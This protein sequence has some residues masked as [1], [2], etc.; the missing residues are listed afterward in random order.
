M[1]NKKSKSKKRRNRIYKNRLHVCYYCEV[2]LTFEK[3]TVDHLTPVSKGGTNDSMN[4]VLACRS[5]N[6]EKSDMT[7]NKYW[8]FRCDE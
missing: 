6:M 3:A 7:E 5:C 2:P 8:E 1:K 4:L